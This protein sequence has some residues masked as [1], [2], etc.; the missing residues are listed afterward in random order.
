MLPTACHMANV[1]NS[2]FGGSNAA[3]LIEEAPTTAHP[4]DKLTNGTNA[5]C[6]AHTNGNRFVN[7]STQTNNDGVLNGN[8]FAQDLPGQDPSR[9][10]FVFSAKTESS[11]T[12]YLSSFKQFL[13]SA[14]QS[15]DFSRNLSFTL[16]QRRTHYPYRVAVAANSP[17]SL[18][19]QLT[20]RKPSKVKEPTIAFVFTGQGAQ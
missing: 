20:G 17:I 13:E 7:G 12:S 6:A 15:S 3:V 18:S 9:R 16:G 8:S 1:E 4:S 14:P 5:N 11:L 2:G 19:E 10:L